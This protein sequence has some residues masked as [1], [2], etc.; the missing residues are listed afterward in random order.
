MILSQFHPHSTFY[1]G[2]YTELHLQRYKIVQSGESQSTFRTNIASIVRVE[3]QGKVLAALCLLVPCF[4][5]FSR[6]RIKAVRSP[7]LH[8]VTSRNAVP[9]T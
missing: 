7:E 2:G 6:V 9:F 1:R 3:E 5:Y 8:G 4:V